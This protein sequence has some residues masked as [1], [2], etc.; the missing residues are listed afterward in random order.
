MSHRLRRSWGEFLSLYNS[1]VVSITFIKLVIA[2]C[3]SMIINDWW[4]L[5]T[6]DGQDQ[7]VESCT[8]PTVGNCNSFCN[9][10]SI[11]NITVYS[12]DYT[13]D[14]DTGKPDITTTEHPGFV[15][16]CQADFD[17]ACAY[18][19][20]VQFKLVPIMFHVLGFLLQCIG[21]WFDKTFSPQQRQYNIIIAYIYPDF[22]NGSSD[23]VQV[24][25]NKIVVTLT[26]DRWKDYKVMFTELMKRPADSVF[27]FLE[28]LTVIYVWGELRF[29]PIYCGAVRPLSLYFYPI[30]MTMIDLIKFNAYVFTRLFRVK[31]YG[32]ALMSLSNLEFF[33][34]NLWI[35]LV[36]AAAFV[37]GLGADA[38][39]KLKWSYKMLIFS[40]TRTGVEKWPAAAV[41]N[42]S[43][44]DTADGYGNGYPDVELVSNPIRSAVVD[45]LDTS[46]NMSMSTSGIDKDEKEIGIG[47]GVGMS[48]GT[49]NYT[50]KSIME[51]PRE[52]L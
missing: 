27:S 11:V 45:T 48:S 21:W 15:L 49:E 9:D 25:K 35:T 46:M 16:S 34:T 5:N 47:L 17:G 10:V 13:F 43:N 2:V 3:I 32:E 31:C 18:Q 40:F 51:L 33:V 12:D 30:L 19:F 14:D 44:D 38:V 20:W 52:E 4:S 50:S 7:L 23:T 36:L 8:N 26:G 37:I 1:A 42:V 22:Y 41:V 29:P 39:S 6:T 28:V 24:E